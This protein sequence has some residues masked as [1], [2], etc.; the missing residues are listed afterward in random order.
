M[1]KITLFF[2][3]LTLCGRAQKINVTKSSDLPSGRGAITYDALDHDSSG[4]YY[5]RDIGGYGSSR[6]AIQKFD[7][8]KSSFIFE[9]VVDLSGEA[10]IGGAAKYIG[11][12]NKNDRILV[13]SHATKGKDNH[14]MM[15]K[16]S[17]FTG[18]EM[19]KPVILDELKDE[20]IAF[21][22]DAILD[23]KITFSP[24]NKKMLIV[25]EL[26]KDEKI[27]KVKA[28]LYDAVSFEKL[29]EKEPITVYEK[30]TVS[31]FDY[32][33][34]NDGT[35]SYLFAYLRSNAEKTVT[36]GSTF[37]IFKNE[38]HGIGI[39]KAG[40]TE[41]KVI[42][43]PSSGITTLNPKLKVVNDKLVCT[44][45][46]FEGEH[47]VRIEND[48]SN[49]GFFLITIDPAKAELKSKS[50]VLLTEDI[51][52]K[53]A[54]K[55]VRKKFNEAGN[56]D[57]ANF[58]TFLHNGCFYQVIEREI[59]KGR[60]ISYGKEIIIYKYDANNKLEWMKLLQRNTMNEVTG[61]FFLVTKKVNLF[62]YDVPENLLAFPN[63]GEY[64]PNEYKTAKDPKRSVLICASIDDKGNVTR[65]QISTNAEFM[66]LDGHNHLNNRIPESK[67]I[68]VPVYL[69]ASKLR[70]NMISLE[71]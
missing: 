46:Y 52:S 64:D 8:K 37:F 19:T 60:A 42:P 25:S 55:D 38:V 23:F 69:S 51:R 21:I 71:E 7:F 16:F 15:Q 27:Q 36:N 30:S 44:G 14:L 35:F 1:K 57:Y 41:N 59:D 53:L 18:E 31:S 66:I 65:Q 12:F 63:A 9:K 48:I 62:Y 58:E 39:I 13:F 2:L 32:C 47:I 29:W 40:G 3:I 50:F 61:L 4:F 5:F 54:Y 34:D 43:I 20:K 11:A 68:L 28:R 49:T 45:Q 6:H 17:S 33:V 10:Y 26:K 22:S 67:A 70:F 56:K 24:D